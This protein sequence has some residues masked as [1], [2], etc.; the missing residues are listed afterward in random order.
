[1]VEFRVRPDGTPVFMEVNGRFWNSLPLSVY[2]GA[3]FPA[4]LAEMAERGDVEA[5]SGYRLG[6][7]CRW[8]LGDARHLIE[9]WRGAPE[10]YAGKYP[11]RLRATLDFLTPVRGTYHDNFMMSDAMPELGDWLDFAL[12]RVPSQFKKRESDL[13]SRGTVNVERRYSRS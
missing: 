6:V 2:A 1:M 5:A 12:R 10:G 11:G 4:R 9:V 13:E 3:D 8:L 7:R